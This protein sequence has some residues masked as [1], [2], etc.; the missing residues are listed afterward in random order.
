VSAEENADGADMD[1]SDAAAFATGESDVEDAAD[2]ASGDGGGRSIDI[3]EMLLSTEPAATPEA[4]YPE[5]DPST[6][7]AMIGMKKALNAVLNG[8]LDRGVTAFENFVR[9]GVGFMNGDE[10]AVDDGRDTL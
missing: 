10:S 7:H 6:A 3:K 2:V 1:P 9:A 5:S 4:D 8:D